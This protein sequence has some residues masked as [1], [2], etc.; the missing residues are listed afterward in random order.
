MKSYFLAMMVFGISNAQVINFPDPV[1]K[2]KLL[3]ADVTNNLAQDADNNNIKIDADSNGEIEQSEAL[4]VYRLFYTTPPPF[5]PTASGPSKSIESEWITDITGISYFT[6]LRKLD[7]SDNQIQEIDLSG[8]TF[9]DYFNCNSNAIQSLDLTGL[10]ALT[11][12]NCA[13]NQ[14]TELPLAGLDALVL[15]SC[16]E[17]QLTQLFVSGLANLQ[18]LSCNDNSLSAIHF[19]GNSSL[20]YVWCYFNQLQQIDLTGTAAVLLHCNDNPNLTT[21]KVKNNV[22]SPFTYDVFPMPPMNA[23]EFGNLPLLGTVCCDTAEVSVM[24]QVL[25]AQPTVG[26]TTDCMPPAVVHFPDSQ[27]KNALLT[28]N[29]ADFEGDMS[30]DGDADLNND[31]EIDVEEALA[32]ANLSIGVNGITDLEGL[33][34]FENLWRFRIGGNPLTTFS[35]Y[36][37]QNLTN[38][39]FNDNQLTSVDLSALV[40]LDNFQMMNEPLAAID[41]SNNPQLFFARFWN[42]PVTTLNFCGTALTYFDGAGLPNLTYFSS[43]NGIITTDNIL[44]QTPPPLSPIILTECPMLETV[45]HDAGEYAYIN[46]G[47]PIGGVNYVTDCPSDCSILQKETFEHQNLTLFPNPAKDRLQVQM[48]S[49]RSVMAISVYNISGQLLIQIR[50]TDTIDVSSLSTGSYLIQIESDW[51]NTTQ[52]FIKL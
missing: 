4:L 46:W 43:R 16:Y 12:L 24:E 35:G 33:Q 13:E 40:S 51:G 44:P 9:L 30:L 37:L 28:T 27:F 25:A 14:L 21:I 31:G 47:D 50:S 19:G 6:N 52:K 11:Y 32:I 36:G 48:D 2:A 42:V 8:L 3:A 34:Y 49:G 7:L 23:F 29:C 38:L 5:R 45:C 18:Y 41:F 20:T 17:N 22:D 10:S 26:I 1:F 39:S 15:L